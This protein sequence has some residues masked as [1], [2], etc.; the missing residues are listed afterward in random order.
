MRRQDA[1]GWF[2]VAL[3]AAVLW[4]ERASA[5]RR[6]HK[7]ADIL[8][9]L[10][11]RDGG[12]VW[13]PREAACGGRFPV[14]ILLHGNNP[15]GIQHNFLGGGRNI[16]AIARKYL[17]GRYI[18]PVILAEPVHRAECKKGGGSLERLWAD[19]FSFRTY[20]R[21]L[22]RALRKY[23]IRPSSWSVIGHS[24]AGCCPGAGVFAAARVFRPLKVWATADT[25]YANP[26]M[27]SIP[28]QRFRG[29]ATILYNSCRGEPVYPGYRVYARHMYTARPRRIRCDRHYYRE[30]V[31]HPYRPWYGLVVRH[32]T[33]KGH[34]AVP[35]ELIK[36]ILWRHFPSR[37]RRLAMKRRARARRS[38]AMRRRR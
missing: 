7:R 6:C 35:T 9:P 4:P 13:I 12:Q 24:G 34:E 38:A 15:E 14:M 28:I 36:T 20:R 11:Y 29:T 10:K 31:K 25:C 2:L 3:V 26:K 8:L 33:V 27:W 23:R 32:D 37:W 5:R 30:C 19:S 17:D 16:D 1:V 18:V 22:L 21:L